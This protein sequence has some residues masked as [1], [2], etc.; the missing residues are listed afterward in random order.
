MQLR[1]GRYSFLMICHLYD[2]FLKTKQI[3][4]LIFMLGL[5][6]LSLKIHRMPSRIPWYLLGLFLWIRNTVTTSTSMIF[7]LMFATAFGLM[8]QWVSWPGNNNIVKKHLVHYYVNFHVFNL[9]STWLSQHLV[10]DLENEWFAWCTLYSVTCKYHLECKLQLREIISE[11]LICFW[12]K[13]NYCSSAKSSDT[14]V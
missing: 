13:N 8:E 12:Q 1:K 5:N 3:K 4:C 10:V 11:S 14:V 2:C 6:C 7:I 9:L